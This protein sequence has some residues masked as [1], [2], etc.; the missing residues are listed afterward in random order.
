MG[1]WR[2][3]VGE[4]VNWGNMGEHDV[5]N[6]VWGTFRQTQVVLAVQSCSR[7]TSWS[8]KGDKD[9]NSPLYSD[10]FYTRGPAP[11]SRHWTDRHR[12]RRSRN[13]R[14]INPTACCLRRE[15]ASSLHFWRCKG[16]VGQLKTSKHASNILYN[17]FPSLNSYEFLCLSQN[18]NSKFSNSDIF[19][20]VAETWS[21]VVSQLDEPRVAL[22]LMFTSAAS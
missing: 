14:H 21:C 5:L 15:T 13:R 6:D 12:V 3:H 9:C 1:P 2:F 11:N 8:L 4:P 17:L 20:L 10:P 7:V 22:L 16:V 19:Q 18:T